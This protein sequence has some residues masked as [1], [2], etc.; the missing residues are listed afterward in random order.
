MRSSDKR[1]LAV[2]ERLLAR[3]DQRVEPGLVDGEF[4]GARRQARPLVGDRAACRSD[5]FFRSRDSASA[6]DLM[7]PT[8]AL[9]TPAARTAA[10][11][12]SGFTRMAGGAS[13]LM[14]CSAASR[15]ADP[16]S[17]RSPNEASSACA[18]AAALASRSAASARSA[19]IFCSLRGRIEQRRVE[20]AAI[21]LDRLD[22]RFDLAL[23]VARGL[24]VGLDAAQLQFG[25]G[26]LGLPRVRR[27][28][29][30]QTQSRER[31]GG[32]AQAAANRRHR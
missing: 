19:S 29:A 31:D 12:S 4:F 5:A 17:R 32:E 23:L 2:A 30:M 21:E 14:R 22:V 18:S 24:Q 13:W 11:M 27:G 28:L 1:A 9:T 16:G 25:D 26:A 20:P 15:S 6:A 3:V 8:S 7:S 10:A